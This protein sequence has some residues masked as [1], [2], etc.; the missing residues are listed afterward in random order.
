MDHRHILSLV[1][2]SLIPTL[3]AFGPA[4]RAGWR[5]TIALVQLFSVSIFKIKPLQKY[6]FVDDVCSY[7][8]LTFAAGQTGGRYMSSSGRRHVEN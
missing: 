6:R 5:G 1:I 4:A 7:L 2:S 8:D 3:L